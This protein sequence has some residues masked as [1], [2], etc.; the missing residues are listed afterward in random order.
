[1]R[2]QW[3]GPEAGVML[4]TTRFFRDGALVDWEFARLE[5]TDS[6]TVLWPYPKGV[7]SARGFPLVRAGAEVVFENLA[8]DFP[9]RIVYRKLGPDHVAPRIEGR[10]GQG[11][12]WELRRVPCPT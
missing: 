1:M 2:E 5:E 8:H 6:A 12:G 4:G 9:V 3:S 7:R 10:D 11:P